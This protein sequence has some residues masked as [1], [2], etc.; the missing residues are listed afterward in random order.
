MLFTGLGAI[1][2]AV[3]MRSLGVLSGSAAWAIGLG[4][5]PG[6]WLA[7]KMTAPLAV[8]LPASCATVGL[9][10]E[11]ALALNFGR[12]A[13]ERQAWSEKELW[14]VLSRTVVERLGVDPAAVTR[15]ARFVEDLGAG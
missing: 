9:A 5:L 12:I 15:D 1:P 2:A 8:H 3:I 11:A 4:A 10:T 13:R 6:L 7:Y 14:D